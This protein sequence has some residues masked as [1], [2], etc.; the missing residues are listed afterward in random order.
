MIQADGGTRT[1]AITGACVALVD[2]I[3]YLQREKLIKDDP[4][5]QM[6]ASVSVGIYQGVPVLDLDYSEDSAADTD[7]NVIMGESGGFIEVQGTAERTPFVRDGTR[8]HAGFGGQGI[9]QL[10]A[11]QKPALAS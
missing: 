4:L 11:Q 9:Q 5:L 3:N 10:I 2:A 6:V 8:W 1:A 7:M